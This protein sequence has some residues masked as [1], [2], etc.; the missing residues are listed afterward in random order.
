M[1]EMHLALFLKAGCDNTNTKYAT[2]CM[3]LCN[4]VHCVKICFLLHAHKFSM[5]G[6]CDERKWIDMNENQKSYLNDLFPP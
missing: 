5:I 3:Y 4:T 1:Y 2:H 6:M